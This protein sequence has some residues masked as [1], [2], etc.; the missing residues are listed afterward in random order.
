MIWY[1]MI[2]AS[3][4]FYQW[5]ADCASDCDWQLWSD[6]WVSVHW[7]CDRIGCQYCS[8]FE[9]LDPNVGDLIVLFDQ[10]GLEIEEDHER[11]PS[12]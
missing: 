10:I 3:A 2:M 8:S 12:H 4:I 9:S 7:L 5:L 1:D 11:R 6:I